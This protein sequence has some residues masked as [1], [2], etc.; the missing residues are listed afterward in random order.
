MFSTSSSC[1][2]L[3]ASLKTKLALSTSMARGGMLK[4]VTPGGERAWFD[5][6]VLNAYKERS[7]LDQED[8]R[9]FQ[10][11][12]GIPTSHPRTHAT[13]TAPNSFNFSSVHKHV[14]QLPSPTR[15][16]PS[17]LR[18]CA[19]P[20]FYSDWT[21]PQS[22]RFQDEIASLCGRRELRL[23]STTSYTSDHESPLAFHDSP[24]DPAEH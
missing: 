8:G 10:R 20:S 13:P 7:A 14:A 19:S 18:S 5:A 22:G 11:S 24:F 6:V 1:F 21:S 12:L 4:V 2:M 15:P 16:N 23:Q 17:P 9:H 3:L